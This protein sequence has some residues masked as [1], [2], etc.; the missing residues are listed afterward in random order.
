VG[1]DN[2]PIALLLGNK[3]GSAASGA[4]SASL[5]R[6]RGCDNAAAVDAE[7]DPERGRLRDSQ[8]VAFSEVHP[9]I[10]RKGARRKP[11]A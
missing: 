6:I 3:G 11:S 8:T 1:R 10:D 7:V 9:L 4:A 2:G 5:P